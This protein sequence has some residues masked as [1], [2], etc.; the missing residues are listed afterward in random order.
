MWIGPPRDPSASL[1]ERN[2]RSVDQRAVRARCRQP[3][4]AVADHR[5]VTVHD[6]HPDRRPPGC[7]AGHGALR[8]RPRGR[9]GRP[10]GR[11]VALDRSAGV[12]IAIDFGHR[13][14]RVALYDL[15]H[16]VLV[17]RARDLDID[18][19]R[20]AVARRRRRDRRG[21]AR[22]GRRRAATDVVGVG[23]GLPGPISRD[24]GT[25]GLVDDPPAWVAIPVA[26]AMGDR[27]GLPVFADNDANLGALAETTFGAGAGATEV[28][29]PEDLVG[30]RRRPRDRRPPLPR[31]QRHRRRDRAT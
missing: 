7:R 24:T 13:R 2:R 8:R 25:L 16:T 1:R 4:G 11:A 20:A 14:L 9:P 27:L 29:L 12:V 3:R 26:A 19:A 5:P 18:G 23:M 6:L 22:R 28:G 21:A 31:G 17:E 30:H 10:P 15:A